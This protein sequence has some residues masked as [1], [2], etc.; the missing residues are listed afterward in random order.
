MALD[1]EGVV[2]RDL[3]RRPG[4]GKCLLKTRAAAARAGAGRGG[5]EAAAAAGG[6]LGSGER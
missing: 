1:R 3:R 4:V 6:A 2:G 5:R